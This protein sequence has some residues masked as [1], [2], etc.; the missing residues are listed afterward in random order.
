MAALISAIKLDPK[1]TVATVTPTHHKHM[2]SLSLLSLC[3]QRER[4]CSK[5]KGRLL[6]QCW[7]ELTLERKDWGAEKRRN[8]LRT[9]RIK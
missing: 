3:T 6:S 4:I 7:V 9:Q 5:G 2:G 1:G 8:H